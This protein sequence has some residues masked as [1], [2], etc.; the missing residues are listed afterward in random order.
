MLRKGSLNFCS[1]RTFF[2]D[3]DDLVRINKARLF[4]EPKISVL[5]A[6]AKLAQK[7]ECWT[8]NQRSK[9]SILNGVMF[10]Y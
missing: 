8:W 7:G 2:W 9:G 5:Q 1:C 3:L 6:N 4:Q 10:Y